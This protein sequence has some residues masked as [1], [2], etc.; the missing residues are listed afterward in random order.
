MAKLYQITT[1]GLDRQPT[2]VMRTELPVQEMGRWLATCYATVHEH[3]RRV[4]VAPVGPPFARFTFLGDLAAV[5]AGF[6]VEREIDGD[7]RVEPSALPGGTVA[8]TTH[9]GRYEDL[10][11]AYAAIRG[12]IADH[13]YKATGPHWE[14]Y[15]TDPTADPDSRHWRTDVVAPYQ[16]A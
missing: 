15:F 6:P 4:A 16:A 3:L 13:G 14:V 9:L 8:M 10:E 7:G 12:W 5:E 2:A 11:D 1:K